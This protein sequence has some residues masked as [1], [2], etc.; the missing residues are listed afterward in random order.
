MVICILMTSRKLC[1]A[2]LKKD[3]RRIL[4]I[5]EYLDRFPHEYVFSESGMGE[6]WNLLYQ[7][8]RDED[9]KLLSRRLEKTYEQGRKQIT[10]SEDVYCRKYD[11]ITKL[12]AKESNCM[13]D[14][15]TGDH[16]FCVDNYK[17]CLEMAEALR[18]VCSQQELKEVLVLF[19]LSISREKEFADYIRRVYAG[20]WFDEDIESSLKRLEAGLSE[21]KSEI[22]Y[23]LYCIESEVPIIKKNGCSDNQAIGDAMSIDCSPERNRKLVSH[24]LTKRLPEN[25]EIVCELHTKMKKIGS[26]PPD[27]I[28]FCADVQ[29]DIQINGESLAGGIYI[30][31]ITHHVGT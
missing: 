19:G 20:L 29:K 18:Y 12:C 23:H 25:K 8:R 17:L 22:L 27:R 21:R 3:V 6:L 10:W 26:R 14:I 4:N 11:E 15:L 13:K 7:N 28:Y 1:E 5:L 16:Y 24:E 2:I 9:C 30:Y 31:K